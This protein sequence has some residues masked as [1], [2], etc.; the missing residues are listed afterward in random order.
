MAL[1]LDQ[2]RIRIAKHTDCYGEW[3]PKDEDDRGVPIEPRLRG[4]LLALRQADPE[5]EM[6]VPV[7]SVAPQ[8]IWRDFGPLCK[9]AGI[10]RYREPVH[11]LRKSCL[12]DWAA[13]HPAH[14]V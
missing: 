8:N 5:G 3:I 12:T 1:R 13:I 6:V 2:G 4:L 9:R 10:A 7:G 11:A 14:V